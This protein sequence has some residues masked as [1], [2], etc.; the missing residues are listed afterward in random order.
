MQEL[1]R[2]RS[3]VMTERESVTMHDI[4]DAQWLFDNHKVCYL[5]N[6]NFY[7]T[8]DIRKGNRDTYF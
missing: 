8:R 5:L 7:L 4:L 2:P 3:G 6:A 1:R